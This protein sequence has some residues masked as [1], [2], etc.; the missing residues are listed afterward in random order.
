M[1]D[2]LRAWWRGLRHLNHRGYIYIWADVLWFVLSLPVITAPAAWAGLI[3]MSRQAYTQPTADLHDFWEGF[4]EN[5]GRG[6]VVAVANLLFIG[7]NIVNLV[8]YQEQNTPI[9]MALRGVWL[10]ALVAWAAVQMYLW[11]L[12]YELQ[13]PSL[14]GALRNAAVMALLNP[15]FT[16]TLL[17]GVALVAVI[18]TV[19]VAAWPLLTGGLLAS[20]ITF[21]VLD[22]LAAA[23]LREPIR[24][25]VQETNEPAAENP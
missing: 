19:L 7:V 5:L 22:R 4:R 9:A 12:L 15:L 13:Q 10:L 3:K 23:G 11:P 2:A 14:L 25:P 21:A 8:V 17:A 20:V 18:S 24:D 1:I 16:L 6:A